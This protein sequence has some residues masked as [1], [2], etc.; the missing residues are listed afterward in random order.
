MFYHYK[1]RRTVYGLILFFI[2]L[3]GFA[4]MPIFKRYYIADIPGLG[5][6]AQFYVTH[7]IHYGM[8]ALLL[9]LGMYVAVDYVLTRRSSSS[10]SRLI[11]RATRLTPS[12]QV[13]IV[14]LAGLILTGCFMVVKNLPE[15]YFPHGL[16][17]GLDLLHL[18]FCMVLLG[19]T[20]YTWIRRRTWIS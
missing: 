7:V 1:S 9:G 16:V 2:A 15:V 3:S 11:T 10:K 17:I 8:A 20:A 14:S 13:K 6:L 4:Q 12:A 19:A 18:L 5:W